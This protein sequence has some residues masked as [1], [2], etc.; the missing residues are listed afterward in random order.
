MEVCA[1]FGSRMVKKSQTPAGTVP[2]HDGLGQGAWGVLT[3]R[4]SGWLR[5]IEQLGF[6]VALIWKLA[7]MDILTIRV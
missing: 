6:W 4:C 5:W 1:L 3:G 2:H 7:Q